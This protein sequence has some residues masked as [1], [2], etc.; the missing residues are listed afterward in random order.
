MEKVILVMLG[1]LIGWVLSKLSSHPPD[2]ERIP[3]KAAEM[4]VENVAARH[5]SKA[6]RDNQ[7]I[8][9]S[10]LDLLRN[11]ILTALRRLGP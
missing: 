10:F 11:D 8:A 2:S 6:R 5:I 9:V 4:E 7:H 1:I 3:R